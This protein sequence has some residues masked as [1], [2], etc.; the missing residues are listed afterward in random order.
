MKR[1]I[2]ALLLVAPALAADPVVPPAYDA[3]RAVPKPPF[4]AQLNAD[5]RAAFFAFERAR[6]CEAD[7]DHLVG[8]VRELSRELA[9][10]RRREGST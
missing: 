5:Q 4:L 2:L 7:R 8:Q 1:L 6:Q 3:E 9:V 10:A